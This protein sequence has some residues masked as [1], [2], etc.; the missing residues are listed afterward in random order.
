[1]IT[2]PV[3]KWFVQDWVGKE[4]PNTKWT[5]LGEEPQDGCSNRYWKCRCACGVEKIVL[6]ANMTT[7]RKKSWGC[8][9]CLGRF[10]YTDRHGYVTLT[11]SSLEHPEYHTRTR[12]RISEHIYV[13]SVFLGRSLLSH[14][15]VHHKNGVRDDNRIE[16]LELWSTSQPHGQRAI[17]KLAWAREIIETYEKDEHSL[18]HNPESGV[19][20]L[21]F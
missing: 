5:V 1:M 6:L 13:M 20:R 17:D 14:E 21:L 4:F 16:N 11:V 19:V 7:Y 15:S 3:K 2:V 9:S 8:G 12:N 10:R 18:S